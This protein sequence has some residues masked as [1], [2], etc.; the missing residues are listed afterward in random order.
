MWHLKGSGRNAIFRE[1]SCWCEN[2]ALYGWAGVSA[3]G[4]GLV[5]YLH[6]VDTRCTVEGR[7]KNWRQRKI[8]FLFKCFFSCHKML[9]LFHTLQSTATSSPPATLK[10]LHQDHQWPPWYS[11]QFFVIVQSLSLI[12]L[13]DPM[14]CNTPSSPV[15]H[16]LPEFAQIHVHWVSDDIQPS[17]FLLSP[18][19]PALNL[20][21]HQ[22][23][24][25]RVSSL[26][27]V[28]NSTSRE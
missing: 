20:S 9:I 10:L 8:F 24:F 28:A 16:Y 19:P 23:L 21:Q 26:H 18:S 11:S 12:C 15:L 25:Q 27:Q 13:C 14:D 1:Q 5:E 2:A 17:H 3:N 6:N 22:G 4:A 7:E